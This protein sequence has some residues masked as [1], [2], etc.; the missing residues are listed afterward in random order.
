MINEIQLV[1]KKEQDFEKK[2]L[3]AI[4]KTKSNQKNAEIEGKKLY[5]QIIKD[6]IKKTQTQLIKIQKKHDLEL[7]KIEDEFNKKINLLSNQRKNS[8]KIANEIFE[9]FIKELKVE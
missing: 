5:E 9:K 2:L 8:E 1:M 6:Q 3:D 4:E 7:Q